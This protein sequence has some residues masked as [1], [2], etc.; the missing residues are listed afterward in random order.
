MDIVL[1]EP[2]TEGNVGAVARV[3]KNFGYKNLVLVNPVPLGEEV[4]KFAMHAFDIIENA[5]IY[6]K[7]PWKE[8]DVTIGTTGLVFNQYN[9]LRT[10]LTPGQL[11]ENMENVRG[12]IAL[13]FGRESKGLFNKELEKCDF[14]SHIPVSRIYP[15]MNLSHAVAV[16]LYELTK[17]KENYNLAEKKEKEILLKVFKDLLNKIDYQNHRKKTALACF[18][19]ILGR[20]FLSS[21][22]AHSLIGT[23]KKIKEKLDKG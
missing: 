19:N 3:M 23:F 13:I 16:F 17:R 8:Y 7:F 22:E 2:E 18:K 1:F 5:K 9:V 11:K 14:V 12:K 15:V 21:R 10:A 6:E 20:S 4:R